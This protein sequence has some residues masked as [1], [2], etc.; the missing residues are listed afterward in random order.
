MSKPAKKFIV[1]NKGVTDLIES[2]EYGL[3]KNMKGGAEEDDENSSDADKDTIIEDEIIDEI[4]DIDED[5]GEIENEDDDADADTDADDNIDNEE[6]QN[7]DTCLYKYDVDSDD[8]NNLDD[9][10]DN[11]Y[12]PDDI[13]VT[14]EDRISIPRLTSYERVRILGTRSKQLVFGAKPM[15]KTQVRLTAKM[16]AE[17]E[18]ENKVSPVIIERTLPDGRKEHWKLNELK[19]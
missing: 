10:G 2:E 18:I 3:T 7:N 16:M 14:P 15:M 4:D 17:L 8:E 12:D 6:K 13:V 19:Y 5:D 9:V 11:F 1:K